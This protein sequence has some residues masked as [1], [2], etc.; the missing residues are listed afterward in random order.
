MKR[1]LLL[2]TLLITAC[3]QTKQQKAEQAVKIYLEKTLNDPSSYES[4]SFSNVQLVIDKTTGKSAGWWEINH[5]YRAKNE[6][7]GI[8]SKTE[9][10]SIDTTFSKADCCYTWFDYVGNNSN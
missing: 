6:Y 5:T 9:C 10:F 2:L 4:V 7:G 3:S 8:I 1:I